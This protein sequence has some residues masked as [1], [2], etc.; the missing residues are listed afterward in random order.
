MADTAYQ[1]QYRQ[2]FIAGFEQRQSLLRDTVTTAGTPKGNQYVFLVIDS[3]GDEAVTRGTNGLIPAK[4]DN[5]TQY[6]AI[7]QE[8]HDLRRKTS[9]NIF[10]SQG[11][12]REIMQMNTMAVMNRKI[13]SLIINELNT[14]TITLGDSTTIPSVLIFQR[15]IVKLQNAAIPWDSNITLVCQPSFLAYLEMATEFASADYVTTRPYVDGDASWKDRPMVYKWR[16]CTIMTHPNLPGKGTSSE[17]S[18][19]YHKSAM[20]HAVDTGGM[21]SDVGYEGEQD[22][23]YARTSI[24]MGVK[25]IQNTG[26]IVITTDG[27]QLG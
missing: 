15:S 27:S 13:D 1:T 20:G 5:E 12:Q 9:F 7:L 26:I 3:G 18:F 24:F 2:E 17:K 11:N 21:G 6:T 14:G 10:A 4:A 8:W 22:Y 19:M 23:S 16:N 25:L